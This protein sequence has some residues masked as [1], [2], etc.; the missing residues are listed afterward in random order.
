MHMC[1]DYHISSLT[2]HKK[3]RI[4][5]FRIKRYSVLKLWCYNIKAVPDNPNCPP[6]SELPYNGLLYLQIS[7][8]VNS[9]CLELPLGFSVL[10]S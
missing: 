4:K 9:S 3:I 10:N 2:L 7:I 8:R 1:E 6:L 5:K